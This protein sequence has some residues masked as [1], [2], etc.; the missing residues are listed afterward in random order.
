M[1]FRRWL[2]IGGVI[3]LF[4][5]AKAWIISHPK[6]AVGIVVGAFLLILTEPAQAGQ[7]SYR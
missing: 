7:G 2:I 6:S 5:F 1:S 3:A 4:V